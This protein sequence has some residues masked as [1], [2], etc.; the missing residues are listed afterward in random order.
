M[1]ILEGLFH[2][3]KHYEDA[4]DVWMVEG[5]DLF[6]VPSIT[7]LSSIPYYLEIWLGPSLKESAQI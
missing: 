4:G 1:E 2:L 7:N 3:S 5:L 6:L